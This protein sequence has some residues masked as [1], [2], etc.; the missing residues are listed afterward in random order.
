MVVWNPWEEAA[1]GMA[2]VGPGERSGMVCVEA[3]NVFA[4]AVTLLPGEDWTITQRIEVL[5][6]RRVRFRQAQP[7]G[8]FRKGRG[9]LA[10]VTAWIWTPR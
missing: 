8:A 7:A 4:D 6:P 5:G 10:N 9:R 1:A 2:D 3:A